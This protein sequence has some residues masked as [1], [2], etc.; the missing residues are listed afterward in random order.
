MDLKKLFFIIRGIL[1]KHHNLTNEDIINIMI[2]YLQPMPTGI[3]GQILCETP[4]YN[5]LRIK[6]IAVFPDG[7]IALL[8]KKSEGGVV[9]IWDPDIGR[10][11]MRFVNLYAMYE[12][13][14]SENVPSE[15]VPSEIVHRRN[16]FKTSVCAM[17]PLFDSSLALGLSNGVVL[18]FN[19]KDVKDTRI[20]RIRPDAIL[21]IKSHKC[22]VLSLLLLSGGLLASSSIEGDIAIQDPRTGEKIYTLIGHTEK[23]PA[24]VEHTGFLVSGSG[25]KTIR[26]W[27][28]GDCFLVIHFDTS[29]HSLCSLPDGKM[30]VGLG[31]GEIVRCP[32]ANGAPMELIG[33]H[34][35][36]IKK[37]LLMADGQLMSGSDDGEIKQWDLKEK[38]T[39]LQLKSKSVCFSTDYHHVVMDRLP[40]GML[41]HNYDDDD[42][43]GQRLQLI[44]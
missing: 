9:Q 28:D 16:D 37:L 34:S 38:K 1:G 27:K 17:I 15:Y 33:R 25:D 42:R 23:V 30:I 43:K 3:V 4:K 12:Y 26:V 35:F 21:K 11:Y 41:L 6:A 14:P 39:T 7:K 40:N 20:E 8:R 10:K 22:K 31:S 44:R 29:I 19:T 2:D 24:L 18:V 5:H 36:P 32:L 13:V